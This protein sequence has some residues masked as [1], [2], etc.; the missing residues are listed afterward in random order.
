MLTEFL[1]QGSNVEYAL[2]SGQ[3]VGVLEQMLD[4]S[5]DLKDAIGGEEIAIKE[6]DALAAAKAKQ[7]DAL[8]DHRDD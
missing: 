8:T 1:V 2:S 5:G 3:I 7:V 6:F 4:T